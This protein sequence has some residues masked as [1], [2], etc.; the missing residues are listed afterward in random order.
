MPIQLALGTHDLQIRESPAT[1]TRPGVYTGD[2]IGRVQIVFRYDFD[3]N[4]LQ[5]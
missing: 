5:I 2:F 1:T 3:K 4:S